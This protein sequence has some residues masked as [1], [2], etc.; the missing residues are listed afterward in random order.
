MKQLYAPSAAPEVCLTSITCP[1][2]ERL[3]AAAHKERSEYVHTLVRRLADWFI[4]VRRG[5]LQGE[6]CC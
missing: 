3:Q 5:R 6:A 4:A 2:I 1:A